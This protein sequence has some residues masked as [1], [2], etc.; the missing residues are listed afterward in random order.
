MNE[1]NGHESNDVCVCATLRSTGLWVWRLVSRD[2]CTPNTLLH[3]HT[4]ID[5]TDA[6]ITQ[7]TTFCAH[8]D[9]PSS[10]PARQFGRERKERT[11][12]SINQ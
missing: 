9:G 1:G 12:I 11:S 3:I 4:T 2:V 6:H 10:I 7:H 8:S 5:W